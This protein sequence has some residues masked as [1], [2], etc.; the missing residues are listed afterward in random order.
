MDS[1]VDGHANEADCRERVADERGGVN[2]AAEPREHRSQGVG[3]VFGGFLKEVVA[4][5]DWRAE[6]AV[7][8][9]NDVVQPLLRR[10]NHSTLKQFRKFQ[11]LSRV[12][13]VLSLKLLSKP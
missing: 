5:L 12:L 8:H 1:R 6:F 2:H 10:L 7:A 9:I 4:A 3:A 11:F 13:T